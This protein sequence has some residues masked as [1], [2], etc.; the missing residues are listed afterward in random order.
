M[1]KK[2][3][4]KKPAARRMGAM[5]LNANSPLVMYGS[6]AAGFLLGDKIN[7]AIDK[8]VPADKVDPK[9]VAAGEVGL[10]ALLLFRKGKK[11]LPMVIAG[12]IALGAGAKRALKSFG[13]ISGYQMI[14]SVSGYQDMRAVNGYPRRNGVSG[15]NPGGGGMGWNTRLDL[16]SSGSGLTGRR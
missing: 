9:L 2:K 12:G 1:A 14:P 16:A 6:I 5:A 7:E 4:K 3:G 13:I 11:N 10:G 8:A 15:A